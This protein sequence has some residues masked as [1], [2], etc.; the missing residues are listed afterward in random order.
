M[1]E[2][3]AG[4]PDFWRSAL[5][6]H[7]DIAEQVGTCTSVSLVS[8]VLYSVLQLAVD[9]QNALQGMTLQWWA[10]EAALDAD[11]LRLHTLELR[12]LRFD[13]PPSFPPFPHLH[14]RPRNPT[15]RPRGTTHPAS[16]R[17]HISQMVSTLNP[18]FLTSGDREGCGGA[19][20]PA[21]P[22][23]GAADRGG[24]GGWQLGGCWV[25]AARGVWGRRFWEEVVGCSWAGGCM[26]QEVGCAA[27]W[28]G[29]GAG[30]LV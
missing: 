9:R 12:L 3:P 15:A 21:R 28:R 22:Q 25:A 1:G 11:R 29:V 7:P 4:I 6:N 20:L 17:S 30:H 19:E 23:G 8:W 27:G 26:G 2:A 13:A 18:L 5:I 10:C 24:G 16:L 14:P